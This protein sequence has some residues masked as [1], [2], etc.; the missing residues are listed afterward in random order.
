MAAEGGD[1]RRGVGLLGVPTSAGSHNA[2]QDKA[3][4]ALR[5]AGLVDHSLR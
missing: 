1:R 4:Q 5:A 2:G 3:P